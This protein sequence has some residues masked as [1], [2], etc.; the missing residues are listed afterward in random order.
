[1]RLLICG[2]R[3]WT[4]LEMIQDKLAD[5][6]WRL[7]EDAAKNGDYVSEGYLVVIEGEARGA[8]KLARQAAESFGLELPVLRYY[9]HWDHHYRHNSK[10]DADCQRPFCH[11][12][13]GEKCGPAA[14]PIRNARMLADG[15]PSEVWAFHD[16]LMTSKGT[17]DML[18]QASKKRIYCQL[19]S[20][21]NEV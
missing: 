3:E 8:D 4:D 2:S 10:C 7:L 14:G 6:N 12:M 16:S 9:A 21:N 5:L 13:C 19:F 18:V 1:M 20:H 17:K 11:P 15:V